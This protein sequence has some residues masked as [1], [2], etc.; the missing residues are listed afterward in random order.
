MIRRVGGEGG[1]SGGGKRR[2]DIIWL[3]ILVGAVLIFLN[4]GTWSGDPLGGVQKWVTAALMPVAEGTLTALAVAAVLVGV[5]ANLFWHFVGHIPRFKGTAEQHIKHGYRS[6]GYA[7]GVKVL[8][9]P[10]LVV[11]LVLGAAISARLVTIVEGW[12]LQ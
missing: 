1:S 8:L 4:P 3:G 9:K 2:S 11:T 12:K 6:I 7:L 5:G 10:L